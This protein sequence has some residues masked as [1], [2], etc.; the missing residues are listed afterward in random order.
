LDTWLSKKKN[1]IKNLFNFFL[2]IFEYSWQNGNRKSFLPFL[3]LGLYPLCSAGEGIA[4]ISLQG[5]KQGW[6]ENYNDS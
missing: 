4:Y 5:V 1:F 2:N 3:S 6:R